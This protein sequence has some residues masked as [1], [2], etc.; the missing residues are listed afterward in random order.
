[1]QQFDRPSEQHRGTIGIPGNVITGKEGLGES[2]TRHTG[3]SVAGL[4]VQ[5]PRSSS[6]AR[7]TIAIVVPVGKIVAPHR[8]SAGA[9]LLEVRQRCDQIARSTDPLCQ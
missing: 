9:A 8:V 1:L 7:N 5:R 2:A 6:I 3:S 4:F